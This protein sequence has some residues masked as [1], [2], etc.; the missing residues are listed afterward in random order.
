MT[1]APLL[2]TTAPHQLHQV[3]HLATHRKG[4]PSARQLDECQRWLARVYGTGKRRPSS[5]TMGLAAQL[6]RHPG[7]QAGTFW[8]S[9][10]VLA[11][12]LGVDVRTIR[13]CK[14]W[15]IERGH[16]VQLQR[17][18]RQRHASLVKIA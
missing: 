1:A 15:L 12:A 3:V 6:L 5:A 9:E 10:Q 2:T 4:R 16:L 7:Q 14:R 11:D 8:L 17:G 18:I 13:R